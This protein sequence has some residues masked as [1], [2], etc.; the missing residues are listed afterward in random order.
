MGYLILA[1]AVGFALWRDA[2]IRD[3]NVRHLNRVNASQCESLRNLYN[4]IRKS[5][6]D[7]D[8]A[9]DEL[10]YYKAHPE[11]RAKA[12]ARNQATLMLFRLPPCPP[13]IRLEER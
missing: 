11:E 6:E 9:I 4:V 10:A 3:E 7:S 2:S 13:A 8:K 5:L 1:V 12:H